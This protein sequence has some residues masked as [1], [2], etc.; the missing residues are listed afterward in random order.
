ML[1]DMDCTG[2]CH[3]FYV[4]VGTLDQLDQSKISILTVT[5]LGIAILTVQHDLI[6]SMCFMKDLIEG[7]EHILTDVCSV[8]LCTAYIYE[9]SEFGCH[10]LLFIPQNEPTISDKLTGTP[11]M[12]GNPWN[13]PQ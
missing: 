9:I 6:F 4:M 7:M 2:A 5:L 11:R 3:V 13:L 12:V 8:E 1:E 10:P